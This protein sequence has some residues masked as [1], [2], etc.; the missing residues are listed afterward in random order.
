MAPILALDLVDHDMR[1]LRVLAQHAYHRIGEFA[2]DLRLLF[3]RR[4]GRHLDIDEGHQLVS[5]ELIFIL[6]DPFSKPELMKLAI[7]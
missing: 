6:F 2:H 5:L 7:G 1:V 3:L 4:A